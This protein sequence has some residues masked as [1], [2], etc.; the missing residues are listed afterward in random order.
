M[1]RP[2]GSQNKLTA[3]LKDMIE[4]ALQDVGGRKYLKEQAEK[5]P[6]AFM[7][8]IGKCL[9][10]DVNASVQG[11]ITLQVVTGVPSGDG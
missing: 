9:P 3:E 6:A 2:K 1:A 8:L 10:K 4:G 7:A 11:N 5:N